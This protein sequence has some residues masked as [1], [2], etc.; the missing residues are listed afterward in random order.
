MLIGYEPRFSAADAPGFFEET[1]SRD[2]EE[3][4]SHSTVELRTS[5]S[6]SLLHKLQHWQHSLCPPGEPGSKKGPRRSETAEAAGVTAQFVSATRTEVK[7]GPEA[8][9]DCTS[10]SNSGTVRASQEHTDQVKARGVRRL[11]KIHHRRHR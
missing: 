10:C 8:F 5:W 2:L 11:H 9:E 1:L 3:A 7:Q 6:E 4:V